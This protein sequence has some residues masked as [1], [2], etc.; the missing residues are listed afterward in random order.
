MKISFFYSILNESNSLC[1]QKSNENG[2]FNNFTSNLQ[3]QIYNTVSFGDISYNS[4]IIYVNST[5]CI[6]ASNL[7]NK[8]V[9]SISGNVYLNNLQN[10]NCIN[11]IF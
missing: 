1:L 7:Y 9:N 10:S 11:Y 2:N 4:N 8:Y 5:S 6:Y 3:S